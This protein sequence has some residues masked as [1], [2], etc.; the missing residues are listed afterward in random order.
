MAHPAVLD[1]VQQV[2]HV[3]NDDIA[4]LLQD[5]PDGRVNGV[6]I[7]QNSPVF[8]QADDS[9]R[10]RLFWDYLREHYGQLATQVGV[11]LLRN[12]AE[13]GAEGWQQH[14]Q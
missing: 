3:N 11:I 8:D 9:Q 7:V 1:S 5:L 6:V 2:F 4:D 12:A 10:I 14:H 13:E